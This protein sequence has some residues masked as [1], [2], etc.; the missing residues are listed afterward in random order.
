MSTGIHTVDIL[1]WVLS[2]ASQSLDSVCHVIFHCGLGGVRDWSGKATEQNL[3]NVVTFL[4]ENVVVYGVKLIAAGA[5][6]FVGR[7]G[8]KAARAAVSKY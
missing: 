1:L 5:I 8:A 3:N 6:F 4:Q 7:F 2:K